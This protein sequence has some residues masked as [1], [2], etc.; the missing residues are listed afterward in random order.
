MPTESGTLAQ[1]I[2]TDL[3]VGT[4]FTLPE[5][6]L[7]GSEFTIPDEIGNVLYTPVS[8]ITEAELT[9]RTVGGTGLFDG[10]MTALSAHIQREYE[11][12]RITG[13]EYAQAYVSMASN[14]L[15]QSVQF[16]LAK[17][18]SYWQALL[19]QKQA[20][21]AELAVIN[22]RVAL[23]QTKVALNIARVEMLTTSAGYA[24]SKMQLANA[25]AQWEIF[26]S[27]K[28]QLDYQTVSLMPADLAQKVK[29]TEQITSEIS[30]SAYELATLMPSQN[31]QLTAQTAQ[32]T[33]QTGHIGAQKSQ[34]EYQTL[35]LM[36]AELAQTTSQTSQIEAQTAKVL[37]ENLNLLPAQLANMTAQTT[38]TTAETSKVNYQV[39]S[40]LPKE[41]EKM[42]Y[43]VTFLLP[44]ELDKANKQIEA[45]TSEISTSVAKKDQILY[46]TLNIL[47][48][49]K[50]G[51]V[52]DTAIKTYQLSAVYP[53][54]VAGYTA[55][56][57][58]KD[59]TTNFLLPAQLES[60]RE[61][62]EG[63]R[64]KTLDTR[65]DGVTIVSGAVGKQK[66]LQQQQIDS[67]KRDA[68]TKVVKL[69][70]DGWTVDKTMDEGV[71]IPN[72]MVNAQIDTAMVKIRTNLDL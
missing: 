16:L 30:K 59:Y 67:Y 5:V 24:L 37:Y 34:T 10:L 62:T 60:T 20:Q 58:S 68:E 9:D 35:S 39:N 36:P 17:E 70:L 28:A 50:D 44:K 6:D 61:Q 66:D 3:T 71:N 26:G 41:L 40:M 1:T 19:A 47:P 57:A 63:H 64:A 29:Q 49:Q 45:I 8:R 23:E 38:Q 13:G 21:A 27:Q 69:L 14:A 43:E 72:S 11:K 33:A 7:S 52:A 51:Y 54:Q 15:A 53:A 55:D 48:A 46:E 22:G 18:Q 12:G 25:D 32:V 56:T 4:N 65:T 31:A 2:F 42:T